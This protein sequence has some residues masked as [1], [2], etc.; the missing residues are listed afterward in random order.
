MTRLKRK[1]TIWE[2]HEFCG[3]Y[4]V[5]AAARGRTD[6][7]DFDKWCRL[8]VEA[9]K[10]IDE[11]DGPAYAEQAAAMLQEHRIQ[12]NLTPEEYK[13]YCCLRE[14]RQSINS[15]SNPMSKQAAA[16]DE[17]LIRLM[18]KASETGL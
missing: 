4:A 2:D 3:S 1:K 11:P 15:L 14:A 9:R 18:T 10:W 8:R 6:Q 13:E 16:E 17:R 5:V 7:A 12:E